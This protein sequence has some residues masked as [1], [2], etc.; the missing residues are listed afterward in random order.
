MTSKAAD[1]VHLADRGLLRPGMAADITV[2]D[3]ATIRD[4]A[5]FD[6][7]KHYAVG[8]KQV[9]V[10]GRRVVADGVMTSERPGRALRGP[11]YQAPEGAAR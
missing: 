1:R 11:A 9:I 8:V 3:P 2:F 6:D 5:T 10:N 7:P 4:A